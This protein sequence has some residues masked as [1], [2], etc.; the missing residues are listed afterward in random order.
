MSKV[1]I[2]IALLVL[3]WQEKCVQSAVQCDSE[4]DTCATCFNWLASSIV[5][6]E[7]NQYNMQK[8]FF[9]PDTANPVYVTVHYIFVMEST[10]MQ[11]GEKLWFWSESTYYASFHPLRIYQFTSLFF[12]DFV[13][14]KQNLTLTVQVDDEMKCDE[15]SDEFMMLLTQRVR[16]SGLYISP[17]GLIPEGGGLGG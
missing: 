13:F 10:G 17:Q 16:L 15:A 8:A 12:G 5:T 6:P 4:N 2:L 7:R 3:F 1:A 11:I 9:P 14:R